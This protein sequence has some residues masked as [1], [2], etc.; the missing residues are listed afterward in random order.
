MTAAAILAISLA[1]GLLVVATVALIDDWNNGD[2]SGWQLLALP[3]AWWIAVR[4]TAE[5]FG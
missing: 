3:P 2:R 5:A 4:F 1:W